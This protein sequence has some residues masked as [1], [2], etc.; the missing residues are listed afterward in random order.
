MRYGGEA[1]E[2]AAA[3]QQHRHS[4]SSTTTTNTTT[5][6]R[7]GRAAAGVGRRSGGGGKRLSDMEV[8]WAMYQLLEA[9]AF[10]HSR[11]V[12][13][14]DVK[15]SNVL[16]SGGRGC[17]SLRLTVVDWGLAEFLKDGG[18][19][20]DGYDDTATNT[21][22]GGHEL[23]RYSCRVASR[24]Y[25]APEL[26]LGNEQYDERL[27]SWSAG[28]VLAG[29]IFQREP[30]FRGS[31][32]FDQVTKIAEVL[33]S[34]RLLAYADSFQRRD[35]NHRKHRKHPNHR[36]VGKGRGQG[37]GEGAGQGLSD[38]LREAVGAPADD[39]GAAEQAD[40]EAD[41]KAAEAGADDAAG[42]GAGAGAAG[43]AGQKKGAVT[44]EGEGGGGGGAAG[45]Q[46]G[47]A[48]PAVDAPSAAA[49]RPVQPRRPR[50]ARAAALRGPPPE[51]HGRRRPPAPLLRARQETTLG[52]DS[53]ALE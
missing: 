39:L 32:N 42:A 25:K 4:S 1:G 53:R 52:R 24:Y 19:S 18:G 51:D 33:G 21:N 8:R 6:R 49:A 23:P 47:A 35:R 9:L 12:M 2:G 37:L 43:A 16:V 40:Q 10:A 30:F 22:A 36:G 7:G 26:L 38:E 50:P 28:C 48:A 15:P 5:T 17:P 3:V 41:Q 45:A 14:R 46:R 13:H 11:G 44:G 27:D 34:E 31:D 29:L 20:D